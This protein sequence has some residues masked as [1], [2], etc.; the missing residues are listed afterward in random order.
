[1]ET[2]T[3]SRRNHPNK[4]G[5]K[6][7]TQPPSGAKS[8]IKTG[9]TSVVPFQLRGNKKEDTLNKNDCFKGKG[10][11][12]DRKPVSG[13][14]QRK[15]QRDAKG[16]SAQIKGQTHKSTEA[17]APKRPAPV[18]SSKSALGM[19]KG[20]IVQ[21]KI[22]SIWKSGDTLSAAVSKPP[23]PK[24]ES[25]KVR[26]LVTKNRSKSVAEVSRQVT[27]RPVPMRSK[28]VSDKAHQVT[29][30]AVGSCR[31]AGTCSSRPPI[32]T[33][34]TTLQTATSRITTM[35]PIKPGSNQ[36][37]NP[38]IP[39]TDKKAS[40]PVVSSTLSQFRVTMETVE[41]KRAKLAEWLASKGKTLKRPAMTTMV[42]PKTKDSGKFKVDPK[43]SGNVEAELAPQCKAEPDPSLKVHN[44]DHE[45]RALSAK[46]QKEEIRP[47]SHSPGIMNTTLDLLDDSETDLTEPQGRVDDVVVN[48]CDALEAMVTPS[49][50]SD[51]KLLFLGYCSGL[52][53][54]LTCNSIIF[55]HKLARL[56]IPFYASRRC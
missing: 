14:A 40:K 9:N 56:I 21:S 45:I 31:P 54:K 17:E 50:S 20:R 8:F 52:T 1:M 49:R 35:A 22:G 5:N 25:E 6:E 46:A 36:N 39:V 11:Q 16:A 15:L 10:K 38:K 51:C 7:N 26:V 48:L 34:T 43:V 28:S 37:P 53:V 27:K 29:R 33:L 32:R 42:P 23:A 4:K 24:P 41:E 30:S 2:V 44:L 13:E 18:P 12:M 19:Y 55:I 47:Q 3:I